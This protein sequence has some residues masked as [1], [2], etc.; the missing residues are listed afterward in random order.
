MNLLVVGCIAF[1]CIYIYTYYEAISKKIDT[2]QESIVNLIDERQRE[3]AS[4]SIDYY[5]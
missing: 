4:R 2:I 3:Q 1:L 5:G